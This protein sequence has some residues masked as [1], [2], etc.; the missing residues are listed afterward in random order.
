MK[1]P[2]R[3]G[4]TSLQKQRIWGRSPQSRSSPCLF[5]LLGSM[6]IVCLTIFAL[7]STSN[8]CVDASFLCSFRQQLRE[9]LYHKPHRE[10]RASS[11]LQ[12]DKSNL[13]R[14]ESYQ[15]MLDFGG[16]F[17]RM[18]VGLM[19][20]QMPHSWGSPVLGSAVN[21]EWPEVRT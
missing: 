14:K 3:Y 20:D 17:A 15:R 16:A 2:S 10:T 7:T 5:V 11:P 13:L 8:G 19:P 18:H 21:K 9:K 1:S 4:A 12:Q 6:L